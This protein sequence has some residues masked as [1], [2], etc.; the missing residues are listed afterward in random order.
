MSNSDKDI[1]LTFTSENVNEK[2]GNAIHHFLLRE[3]D[4]ADDLRD[5]TVKKEQKEALLKVAQKAQMYQA[6][7]FKQMEHKEEIAEKEKRTEQARK[8]LKKKAEEMGIEIDQLDAGD[9]GS[10]NPEGRDEGKEELKKKMEDLLGS[11]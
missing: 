2:H 3:M 5:A 11:N 9:L 10:K 6:N 1:Q 4:K 8:R 7:V